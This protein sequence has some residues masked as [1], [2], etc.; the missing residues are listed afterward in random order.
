MNKKYITCVSALLLCSML[1]GCAT[2]RGYIS[3]FVSKEPEAP[4]STPTVSNPKPQTEVETL[5]PAPTVS[6]LAVCGDIMV[7]SPQFND[8][9]VAD[10]GT[11]DFAPMLR[12]VEPWISGA[13]YAVGNLETTFAGGEPSGYPNF[14][15]PDT[16][17]DALSDIGFD[18]L[19]TANNHCM[20]R[21]YAGM[22]RTLDVL[23]SRNLA[24]VGT[25][26]TNAAYMENNGIHLADVGG[27]SVAFLSYSYGTNGIALGSGQ[28]DTVNLFYTDYM[29]AQNTLNT[30]KINADMAAA[31]ALDPDMIAVMVHWGQ[32][33]QLVQNDSQERTAQAFIDAGADMILGGHPHVMEPMELRTVTD[34]DGAEREVFISWSLGNFISSQN[35]EY[36]DTTCV[37]QVELTKDARTEQTTVSNISYVP[38][39]MHDREAEINGERFMLLDARN[40]LLGYAQGAP[41]VVDATLAP[42]LEKCIADCEMIIGQPWDLLH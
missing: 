23:D 9:L 42:K 15:A 11:Y 5:P 8:A 16:L 37:L 2:V 22:V 14:C 36:T 38:L 18:L 28:E 6:T 19:S 35:D 31:K 13:D 41:T 10:T 32:E 34:A 3:D 20:D 27:I 21:G 12:F 24:H 29:G 4:A 33:Y 1:G 17:A 30:E 26:R 40:A 7:H 25:Y 39:Y